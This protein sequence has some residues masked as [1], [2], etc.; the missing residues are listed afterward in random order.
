VVLF[1]AVAVSYAPVVSPPSEGASLSVQRKK[2][3]S[4]IESLNKHFLSS[5]KVPLILFNSFYLVALNRNP[6]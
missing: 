6:D 2:K 4:E 1:F 5:G 3:Q